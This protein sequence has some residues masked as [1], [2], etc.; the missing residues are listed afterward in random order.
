MVQHT[1]LCS[2][3]LQFVELCVNDAQIIRSNLKMTSFVIYVYLTILLHN[4]RMEHFM[5][6]KSHSI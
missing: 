2:D 4:S 6:E 3:L 5:I 1:F